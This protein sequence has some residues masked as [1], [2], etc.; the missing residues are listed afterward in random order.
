MLIL[1]RTSSQLGATDE[2]NG[3]LPLFVILKTIHTPF[4]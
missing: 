4:V 3:T 2:L 1:K